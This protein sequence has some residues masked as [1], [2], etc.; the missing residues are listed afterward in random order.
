MFVPE[1]KLIETSLAVIRAGQSDSGAHLAALDYPTYAWFR[2]GAFVAVA[3]DA[4]GDRGGAGA[5]L[6]LGQPPT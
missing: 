3:A 2:D 4:Y 1:P 6:G 5:Y